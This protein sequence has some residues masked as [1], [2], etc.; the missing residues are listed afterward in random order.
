MRRQSLATESSQVQVPEET[1]I[2]RPLSNQKIV[3]SGALLASTLPP[4]AGA[5][6]TDFIGLVISVVLATQVDVG[7]GGEFTGVGGGGG[8]EFTGGG[9]GG[10]EFT[11]GGGG[12][13][14][15]GGGGGGGGELNAGGGD[16]TVSKEPS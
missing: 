5:S 1:L 10:G 4:L 16:E 15:T 3:P 2:L 12:G 8:G 11:G 7:G 9:G 13:E 14:F 6:E